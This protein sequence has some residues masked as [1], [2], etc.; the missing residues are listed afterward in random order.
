LHIFPGKLNSRWDGPYKI[1]EILNNGT[2]KIEKI[3]GRERL[4]VNEQRLKEYLHDDILR[5]EKSTY[6]VKPT[7]IKD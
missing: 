4:M 5:K 3:K 2:F 1:I 7:Y 6:L